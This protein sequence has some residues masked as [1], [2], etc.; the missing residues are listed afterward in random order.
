MKRKIHIYYLN[1][2]YYIYS[3]NCVTAFRESFS[4]SLTKVLREARQ[5]AKDLKCD[6]WQIESMFPKLS[7]KATIEEVHWYN[8]RKK[9]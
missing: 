4:G 8:E 7:M 6:D 1:A 9:K 5:K 2:L 3:E